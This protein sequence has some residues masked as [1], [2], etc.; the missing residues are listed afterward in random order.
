MTTQKVYQRLLYP[1]QIISLLVIVFLG[2][3]GIKN[4]MGD[5]SIPPS[6]GEYEQHD[7]I[8]VIAPVQK[9]ILLAGSGEV[10]GEL[11]PFTPDHN[12]WEEPKSANEKKSPILKLEID[13]IVV[14]KNTKKVLVKDLNSSKKS[15]W[16]SEGDTYKQF[17]VAYIGKRHVVFTSKDINLLF[18]L[19]KSHGKLY[20]GEGQIIIAPDIDLYLKNLAAEEGDAKPPTTSAKKNK[21]TETVDRDNKRMQKNHRR[22]AGGRFGKGVNEREAENPSPTTSGATGIS[23]TTTS[24]SSTQT[25]SPTSYSREDELNFIL[26]LKKIFQQNSQ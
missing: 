5:V 23:S 11:N 1:F 10:K 4:L 18:T 6:G 8:G 2:G 24:P 19:K 3:M 9:K 15:F 16:L 22:T 26:E 12:D 25:S 17:K 13:G 7:T 14:I 21:K 20:S